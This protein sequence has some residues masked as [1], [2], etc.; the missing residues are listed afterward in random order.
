MLLIGIGL[1]DLYRRARAMP[2]GGKAV[3]VVLVFTAGV[4]ANSFV[5]GLSDT[6]HLTVP[7]SRQLALRDFEALG[8]TA[9]NSI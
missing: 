6:K 9:E 2:K 8:I 1:G 4:L 3:L 7:D 5:F